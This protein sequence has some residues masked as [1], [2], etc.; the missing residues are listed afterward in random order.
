MSLTFS[1]TLDPIDT[2]CSEDNTSSVAAPSAEGKQEKKR[3]AAQ[4]E[5][6]GA[7]S[8]KRAWTG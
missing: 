1:K 3:L 5:T 2:L 8:P 7:S 6:A 4:P